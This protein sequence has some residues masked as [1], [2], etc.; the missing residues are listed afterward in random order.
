MPERAI[1]CGQCGQRRVLPGEAQS[2][3]RTTGPGTTGMNRVTQSFGG[4]G[5][6]S[7]GM[8]TSSG[9]HQ[10][11]QT[12]S[13]GYSFPAVPPENRD[14][15]DQVVIF[16]PPYLEPGSN[17][18]VAAPPPSPNVPLVK[19]TPPDFGSAAAHHLFPA[20]S[21]TPPP[22]P[23]YDTPGNA[24]AAPYPPEYHTA[25]Q[26]DPYSSPRITA[27]QQSLTRRFQ[28]SLTR[29]FPNMRPKRT[30]AV[31]LVVAAV[32][33][34]SG[35]AIAYLAPHT[36]TGT[37]TARIIGRPDP[38]RT[39]I[40][41]GENF[42]AQQKVNI[43]IDAPQE[44]T[45]AA[46][47]SMSMNIGSAFYRHD[48]A[49]QA[50]NVIMTWSK[51]VQ[52]DGIFDIPVIVDPSW[53]PGSEHQFYV[54][55]QD[56]QLVKTLPF[57]IPRAF[58]AAPGNPAGCDTASGVVSVGA[59]TEDAKQPLSKAITLCANG[60]GSARAHVTSDQ[61]WLQ[62]GQQ[63]VALPS[64][65]SINAITSGLAPGVHAG[66]LT[67]DNGSGAVPV[68]VIV[69]VI[70]HQPAPQAKVDCVSATPQAL[71]F[72]ASSGQQAP[73]SQNIMVSNCGSS[74]SWTGF[75]STDTGGQWLDIGQVGGTLAQGSLHYLT[76]TVSSLHLQA[77]TYSG[78]I[79]L[80]IGSSN[81]SVPVT[82][83]VLAPKATVTCLD[84]STHDLTF[85]AAAGQSD[86][87][88]QTFSLINC[89]AGGHWSGSIATDD[90]DSWLHIK[91]DSYDLGQGSA[92]SVI[93]A[94]RGGQLDAGLYT[95]RLI[96]RL[97]NSTVRVNVTL[98]VRDSCVFVASGPLF[99][100]SIEGQDE[101]QTQSITI[102]SLNCPTTGA[103]YATTD[104]GS[105]NWLT[106]TNSQHGEIPPGGS[107]DIT[108]SVTSGQI[109]HG[110]Y[111]GTIVF[112]TGN[113]ITTIPVT[114][115][116]MQRGVS[117]CLSVNTHKLQFTVMKGQG[118]PAPQTLTLGNCGATG[119]WSATTADP[120]LH[121]SASSGTWQ[122]SN[123]VQ[124][125]QVAPD[126][127]GLDVGKSYSS[128]ITFTQGTSRQ[129]VTVSVIVQQATF[130]CIRLDSSSLSL[131]EDVRQAEIKISNCGDGGTWSIP[132]TTPTSWLQISAGKG[133]LGAA[134]STK[135]SFTERTIPTKQG[136]YSV[137]VP[138]TLITSSGETDSA[139]IA[140]TLTI[141]TA[142]GSKSNCTVEPTALTFAAKSSLDVPA[143]QSVTF[144]N[145]GSNDSWQAGSD[146]ANGGAIYGTP[147]SGL[148][149]GNG[150][151]TIQVALSSAA[152]TANGSDTLHFSTGRGVV[153]NVPVSWKVAAPAHASCIQAD[154]TSLPP[155][156]VT[157]QQRS[158]IAKMTVNFINCGAEAGSIVVGSS[159][160]WISVNGLNAI[161]GSRS[162]QP[163]D[164]PAVSVFINDVSMQQ[165]N[166]QGTIHATISTNN[167][168]AATQVPI[169]I[170]VRQ[171]DPAPVVPPPES[172]VTPVPDVTPT[173]SVVT[174]GTNSPTAIDSPT[175]VTSPT[176][177]DSPTVSVS[178]TVTVG[179][180]RTVTPTVTP[181][182]SPTVT[183]KPVTPTSI[184]TLTPTTVSVTPTP[185]CCSTTP[186][187]TTTAPITPTPT[188]VRVTPTAVPITPTP[189]V[190][191]ITPTPTPVRITP[192]AV[193]V[194][195]TSVI[196]PTA[197]PIT[198][199]PT[200]VRI[201][202]TAVPITPTPVRITPT[203]V[204]ITPTPTPVRITP[205]AIPIT[206]TPTPVIPTPT[207]TPVPVQPTPT[208][209]P[210][211]PTPT[212]TPVPVQPTPTPVPVQPTPTPTPTPIPV[213]PTPTSGPLGTPTASSPQGREP[214]F[215]SA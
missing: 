209:K 105:N 89:G 5:S 85:T 127:T 123:D 50:N 6:P 87:D 65:F 116:V 187:P 202:P 12:S 154:P 132:S 24:Q 62:A 155:V 195:P 136:T 103:W 167:A 76:V 43:T 153:V 146:K 41:H 134:E 210:I 21:P 164:G 161:D 3:A 96:F 94:V 55:T 108:V 35:S 177:T 51:E 110:T 122:T 57:S 208:P 42:P 63:A 112:A 16:L 160:N 198:P 95:G 92:Q 203:P 182:V 69:V 140:V 120:W 175:V 97:G 86:P 191:P 104:T 179:A 70:K 130:A 121:L 27:H 165:A 60:A 8:P 28:Q 44:R 178:P 11:D 158:S 20:A 215:S 38:G 37:L 46:N 170:E 207:P 49:R 131:T 114:F 185:T 79:R 13:S 64:Q 58:T 142:A 148:L 204:P 138:V 128:A 1:F 61:K 93:V 193:P 150:A 53:Q 71:S 109:S 151:V 211:I 40:V 117:N 145:C 196:T 181:T 183:A 111:T 68:K 157:E 113:R 90:G 201:T 143:T 188:V 189:T 59:Q 99:F 192:T 137:V 186:T 172:T 115:I 159:S 26:L 9:L 135:L 77:G 74:A 19:G 84:A 129:T 82:L 30:S 162:Y 56:G 133:Q 73:L 139:E 81:M 78:R 23:L 47:T 174:N 100:K 45:A 7:D 54:Y 184:P 176:I 31:I 106:I 10:S 163:G 214:I 101:T 66:N 80:A 98:N 169:I 212:P 141:A 149:D 14:D 83:T 118:N 125:I 102:R 205:T 36:S 72:T 206:P 199:T 22:P 180:T 33:I 67:F 156:I 75:A 88:P 171:H 168:T 2:D 126:T 213:Q 91:P 18:P 190:V 173:G 4:Q 48:Q 144:T 32:I 39:I 119:A 147:S 15:D 25:P 17:V 197:V 152:L 29:R 52:A 34:I 124:D 166:Y 200:P 194:T 107:Q